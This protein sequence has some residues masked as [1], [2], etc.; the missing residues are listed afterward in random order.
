MAQAKA[1]TAAGRRELQPRQR[2][3]RVEVRGH[4]P[5]HVQLDDERHLQGAEAA[6]GR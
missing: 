6:A 4:D 5:G 2:V 3:D 1:D